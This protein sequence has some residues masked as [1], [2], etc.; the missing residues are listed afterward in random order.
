MN[1]G[2]SSP[3]E[4]SVIYDWLSHKS[5][6]EICF[7]PKPWN[8]LQQRCKHEGTIMKIAVI[9][10]NKSSYKNGLLLLYFTVFTS[11]KNSQIKYT[12]VPLHGQQNFLE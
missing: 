1:K 4:L 9:W 10:P 6:Q 5:N 8:G 12:P 11:I 3:T 2:I 7:S